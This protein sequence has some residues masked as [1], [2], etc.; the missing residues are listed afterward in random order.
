[1]PSEEPKARRLFLALW[2]GEKE[3][4]AMAELA[5]K[6][7]GGRRVRTENLHLTL[8]FLGATTDQR[9]V[10]YEDAL[11]GIQVPS[12]TLILDQLGY[13]RK[14]R[15]LWLGA[16]Q[17]PAA[18]EDLVA[19]LSRR[20]AT[21]DFRPETRPFSAHITLARKYSGSVP[22]ELPVEPLRWAVDQITLCESVISQEG[23]RY[24]V[25]RRWPERDACKLFV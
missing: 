15:I 18:L 23:V 9:L 20:L 24:Q 6:V 2:P 16:S 17:T 25:L 22:G 5:R 12:M 13:W 1:M 19:E 7:P 11:Q 4:L 14:S 3:R 10:C 21:C 8:A